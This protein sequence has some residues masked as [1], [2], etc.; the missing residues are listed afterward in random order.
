MDL[1]SEIESDPLS[2]QARYERLEGYAHRHILGE[3]GFCCARED[4]C[5]GSV[6][7]ELVYAAGQLSHVGRHYDISVAGRPLRILVLG[8]DTGRADSGVTMATRREQ[9]YERIPEPFTRRNPHM[10]GTTL[11]L[12]ALLGSEDWPTRAGEYFEFHGE[13]VHVLD[14]YA[15]AN[16]RLCSAIDA[17]ST[18]S[19]GTPVMGRNCLPQLRATI[20]I[21]E[22][23]VIVIQGLNV[24]REA[25]ALIRRVRAL[26]T[27]LELA[28]VA[29]MPVVLASFMH[30]SYPGPT[31]NWSW[32]TSP[33]FV[34]RVLPALRRAQELALSR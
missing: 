34:D 1:V 26:S 10:R 8:M 24:R 23:T 16:L 20:A 30:P 21:L 11:A 25:D 12:R 4:S 17:G 5:R 2:T 31:G 9:V 19:R 28:E 27:E 18:R 7:P 13:P 6:R 15:M 32:P 22:P 29:D 14:G 3:G 33:Y